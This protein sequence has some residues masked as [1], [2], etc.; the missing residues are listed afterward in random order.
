M[1][2]GNNTHAKMESA[3]EKKNWVADLSARLN[4]V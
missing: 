1:S 3:H 4:R 2:H